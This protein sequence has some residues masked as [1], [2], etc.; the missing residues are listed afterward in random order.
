MSIHIRKKKEEYENKKYKNVVISGGAIKGI[1]SLGA[2]QYLVDNQFI[3]LQDTLN[4][5]GTSVGGI[6]SYLLIIGYTPIEIFVKICTSQI[7]DK[8][9]CADLIQLTDGTGAFDWRF[10]NE[11]LE[12]LTM[13]KIGKVITMKDIPILFNKHLTLV[14]YNLT[15]HKTE[16]IT[17]E[18][19]PELPCLI[20]L[21]MT[22]N[23]PI[24]FSRF[25]YYNC[26]YI[27]GG[28]IN[29]IPIDYIQQ[30]SLNSVVISTSIL[31]QES[32]NEEAHQKESFKLHNYILEL[33]LENQYSK[34]TQNLLVAKDDPNMDVLQLDTN[35]Q[36][37]LHIENAK[38]ME[39]FSNGYNLTQSYFCE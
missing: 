38:A 2:L 39:M 14:T 21:R 34:S 27:D 1:A 28:F 29:H 19:H 20:A 16:T 22:S 32:K 7:M 15:Q 3:C 31:N 9:T 5:V 11:F 12:D 13:Q 24:I 23:I 33:F 37:T 36:I 17:H 10:M 26:E 6:I 8:F 30:K 18:S 4:Y 35:C 25:F